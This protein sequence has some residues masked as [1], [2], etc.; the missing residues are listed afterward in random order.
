MKTVFISDHVQSIHAAVLKSIVL[1]LALLPISHTLM[2][3]WLQT[4]GGSQIVVGFVAISVFSALSIVAFIFALLCSNIQPQTEV[5]SQQ[6]ALGEVQ[7]DE[8]LHQQKILR[9]YQHIPMLF[10]MTMMSYLSSQL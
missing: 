10:L 5:L 4:E 9:I 6:L 1:I 7:R 8:Q 2:Q 3:L